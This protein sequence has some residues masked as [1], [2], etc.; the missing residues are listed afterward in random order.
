MIQGLPT[1][2]HL[3]VRLILLLA[4]VAG[5]W[6][7]ATVA[8]PDSLTPCSYS[9]TGLGVTVMGQKG[10]RLYAVNGSTGHYVYSNDNGNTWTDTRVSP[11]V[12]TPKA[13]QLV[14]HGASQF[15][16]TEDGKIFRTA[17][18]TWNNWQE[19]SVPIRPPGT[20]YRA[21]DLTSNG[22]Y[23]YYGNYNDTTNEGGHVYRSADQGASWTEVL[24]VPNARHVHAVRADP[25]DSAHIFVN[26]GDDHY[27]GLGL[28]YSSASGDPGT[29]V[30]LSSNCYGIDFAFPSGSSL[31]LME[32]DGKNAP[33]ILGYDRANLDTPSSTQ[34][35]IWPPDA[36]W[37]G[38]ARS[39]F[40][41]S[42]G[43]LFWISTGENGRAGTRDGVWMARGPTL[44]AS[45][46]L[47]LLEE[48]TGHGWF[49]G[50]TYEAGPY[51][52]NDGFRILR[53]KFR[54]Q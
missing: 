42:E 34:P 43:N 44:S 22:T 19:V 53:P 6:T 54:G 41:T 20:T 11:V 37:K 25:T 52:F 30:H 5:P 26:M 27:A 39:I 40:V 28:W 47:V 38:T 15:A 33:Y 8:P 48:I 51:L 21:D 18:D 10:S 3:S 7:V 13:R 16:A 35:L 29:F 31:I 17:G 1:Q 24:S 23:L 45:S 4:F 2:L 12:V 50:K 14:F 46:T 9:R 49:Y 36:S 32:G